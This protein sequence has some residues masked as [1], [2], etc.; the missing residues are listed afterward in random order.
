MKKAYIGNSRTL[1]SLSG[2]I[3][4][5]TTLHVN[6]GTLGQLDKEMRLNY[7]LEDFRHAYLKL[8]QPHCCCFG[9]RTKD[10]IPFAQS[11][12]C[13][14]GLV[15]ARQTD[16]GRYQADLFVMCMLGCQSLISFIFQ[17]L[18]PSA[19]LSSAQVANACVTPRLA[20]PQSNHIY[21]GVT[22]SLPRKR[23]DKSI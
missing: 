6:S 22:Q 20:T 13:S 11:P 1:Q 4:H 16:W 5:L 9:F 15:A 3:W 17:P 10:S 21:T 12:R 18:I 19:F 14:L 8:S 2:L 23:V 7:V